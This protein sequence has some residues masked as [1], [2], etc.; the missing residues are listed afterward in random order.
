M[1]LGQD[2]TQE[3]PESRGGE[4]QLW[5]FSAEPEQ[6]RQFESQAEQEDPER[7]VPS[8]QE[9]RQVKL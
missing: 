2:D 4:R 3:E 8:G 7:K 9:L 6:V 1:P 5:Q